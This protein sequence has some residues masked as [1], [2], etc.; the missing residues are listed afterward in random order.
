MIVATIGA[1]GGPISVSSCVLTQAMTF[2]IL[3]VVATTLIVQIKLSAPLL[4]V[5]AP[6]IANSIGARHALMSPTAA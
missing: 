3:R 1:K 5:R 6:L 4:R 2:P